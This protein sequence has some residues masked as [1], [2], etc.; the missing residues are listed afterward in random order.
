MKI[1][2]CFMTAGLWLTL[3][4]SLWAGSV[5]L[6]GGTVHTMAGEP[7]NQSVLITDGKIAAVGTDLEAPSDA[8]RVDVSGLQVYPGM[9]DAYSRLGLV[10][11]GSV[12]ATLD[13]SELGDFNPHLAAYTAMHPASEVLPVTRESGITHAVTAPAGSRAG[14]VAGQAGVFHLDG[15][16]VEEMAVEGSAA[17][18]VAWPQIRTR[19]FDFATFTMRETP[20][21]DAKKEAEKAQ[22]VLRDWF[23]AARHYQQAKESGSKRLAPNLKLQ[24]LAK[25]LDGGMPVIITA[26]AERDIEAAAKFAEEYGL[27]WILAGGRDAWKVADLLAEKQVPVILGFPQS[28]PPNEDDPYDRPFKTASILVEAGVKIAFGSAAGSRFGPGGPHGARTLP[29]EAA[30]AVAY[31]LSADE[32]VKALTLNPAEMFGLGDRLGS[33]EVGKTANL[34]VFDGDPLEITSQVRYLLIDGE[35]VTTD[36]RHRSLYE[37]YRER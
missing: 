18:V 17:M 20:F 1:R 36:N 11:I 9:F 14:G 24:H 12:P 33:I 13:T 4:S 21:G 10:E 8:R 31:G 37:R 2:N 16:T 5:V 3:A 26:N 25:V 34:V 22:G 27:S 6:E 7:S 35:L 19:S 30:T 32:A 29:W 15:W 23:D 28:L